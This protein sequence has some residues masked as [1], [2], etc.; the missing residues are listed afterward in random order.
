[1]KPKLQ[2]IIYTILVDE[3]PLAAFEAT[4]TEARGLLKE[5]WFFT[6]LSELKVAVEPVF[7][8]GARLRVRP[9][10]EDEWAAFDQECENAE[11][12]D[13]LVFVI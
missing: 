6:E 3:M 4:A 9:A 11:D 2:S 5:R 1:M 7:K 8:S 12:T 13:G 10:T